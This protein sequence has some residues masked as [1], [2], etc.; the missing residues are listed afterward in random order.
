M[1]GKVNQMKDKVIFGKY[2]ILELISKG[3]FGQIYLAKNIETKKL[4]AVKTENK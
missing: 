1:E 3:S 2:K 4:Y